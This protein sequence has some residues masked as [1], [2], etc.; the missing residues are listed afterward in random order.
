MPRFENPIQLQN[1]YIEIA[2]DKVPDTAPSGK[3]RLYYDQATATLKHSANGAAATR[4]LGLDTSGRLLIQTGASASTFTGISQGKL[5]IDYQTVTDPG[6]T[7][8]GISIWMEASSATTLSRVFRATDVFLAIPA[9]DARLYTGGLTGHNIQCRHRGDGTLGNT[10]GLLIGVGKQTGAGSITDCVGVEINLGTISGGSGAITNTYGLYI[11]DA[12]TAGTSTVTNQY[13][14]YLENQT[15]GGTLKYSIF[16]VGGT[17]Q[18]ATGA[19]ANTGLI[20]KGNSGSQSGALAEFRSNSALLLS[21][22]AAGHLTFAE[23]INIVCGTSTGTQ[24]GTSSSQKIGAYG[25]TPVVRPSAFTQTYATATK[26]H[27]NPT[28]VAVTNA[29]GTA[30]GTFQ[31]TSA[32]SAAIANNFQEC[33][34]VLNQLIADVANCKQVLNSVVD[35]L[36]LEGW[37]A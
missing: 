8:R 27:S 26:T 2:G 4:L 31:D 13:G 23:G 29:F 11:H 22:A 1:T 9:G 36:Q 19:D 21:V 6:D 16:S 3:C 12:G 20:V 35:D 33:S 34:T 37:L 15:K 32:T 17:A 24:I 14:I 18:F 5:A 10:T 7:E 25:T 30:D 28:A